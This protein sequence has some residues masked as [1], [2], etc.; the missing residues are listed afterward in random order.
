M[1]SRDKALREGLCDN[2]AD[3]MMA[4]FRNGQPIEAALEDLAISVRDL[5]LDEV[6][7]MLSG[8]E[9]VEMSAAARRELSAALK[10]MKV[11]P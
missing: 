4:M 1:K 6:E 2:V 9:L 5:T 8:P 3:A 10:R 7:V 11:N